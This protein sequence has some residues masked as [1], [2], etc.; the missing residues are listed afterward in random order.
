MRR[1]TRLKLMNL[2]NIFEKYKQFLNDEVRGSSYTLN[3]FSLLKPALEYLKSQD[4]KSMFDLG[5]GY[6]VLTLMI[7]DFLKVKRVYVADIDEERLNFFKRL[8][9]ESSVDDVIVL[10]QDFCKP[11][12]VN[13]KVH[14]V[15]SFGSL[16]HVICW[17]EVF[18]NIRNLLMNKGY[19]LIS[20]PN[21]GSWVN[22]LALLLGYQPRDIEISKK[23]H[24]ELHRPSVNIVS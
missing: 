2:E 1:N 8:R 21:L 15:T 19:I 5:C 22:R 20:M 3:A 17:D 7:A 11:I 9:E 18:E 12:D 4:I 16:E 6:G 13:E 23:S 24:M 10:H 14:L